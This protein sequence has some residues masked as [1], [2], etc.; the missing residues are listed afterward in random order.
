[1]MHYLAIA[2]AMT[3]FTSPA[4]AAEIKVISAGAVRSV[5]AGMIEDY[6][7]RSGDDVGRRH[8]RGLRAEPRINVGA[9]SG[10]HEGH[11]QLAPR[12]HVRGRLGGTDG[13]RGGNL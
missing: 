3:L 4:S 13:T 9:A 10:R 11:A 7:T 6:R 5:V 8:R 2:I 1:M 12:A